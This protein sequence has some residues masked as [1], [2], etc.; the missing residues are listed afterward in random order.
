M[1]DSVTPTR[2]DLLRWGATAGAAAGLA[3]LL[4][5]CGSGSKATSGAV[6]AAEL[7]DYVPLKTVPAWLPPL[8][9]GVEAGYNSFPAAPP[10]S[11]KQP[12]LKG[13]AVDSFC[14]I[15]LPPPTPMGSN[16]AWQKVNQR[17]GGT[18]NVNYVSSADYQAKITTLMASNSLPDLLQVAPSTG[19]A[20]LY[21]FLQ[22]KC[23][24]L[25]PKLAGSAVRKYPNLA[26]LP[27][28]AWKSSVLNGSL[29]GVP[30]PRAIMGS[31]VYA[32]QERLD[33]LGVSQIKNSDEFLRVLKELTRPSQNQWAVCA[34]SGT[35]FRYQMAQYLFHVP[36]NWKVDSSGHFTSALETEQNKEAVS[37]WR[38]AVAA[39][40]VLPGSES[41]TT[42]QMKDAFK[43]GRAT[44]IMDGWAN[45]FADYWDSMQKIDP[46][47]KLRLL[48]L[49]GA[50]GGNQTFWYSTGIFSYTAIPQSSQQKVD[51]LLGVLN[52]LAAPFGS[53]EFQL[54]Y[55]GVEGL[56]FQRV[57]GNLV[58]TAQGTADLTVPW[59]YLGAGPEVQYDGHSP[60][61]TK[62]AYEGSK[63]LV[64]L[65]VA[66]PTVGLY[67]NTNSTRGPII[68]S[69]FTTGLTDIIAGRRP[70]SDY[71]SLVSAWKSSGG[72]IIRSE[73]QKAHAAGQKKK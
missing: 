38:Q 14:L 61:A 48:V 22:A 3:P 46:S 18:L 15:Y 6:T 30:V 9:N 58:P 56:E 71:D 41:F 43:S 20:N 35:A 36:N 28:F 31:P 49:P 1:T 19:I 59:K 55:Y 34:S 11:V 65:G 72:D 60:D 39:G 44:L 12:P 24:D 57:S 51:Q 8:A 2:R 54:L 40:V 21:P 29:Y 66:D 37:F 10:D 62:W 68:G 13:G 67:S 17:L 27:T 53:S 50:H 64:P 69:T 73:Y 25:T 63:A 52:F 26:N 33:Q 47:F 5:A 16:A 7:P 45:T 42:N 4:A 70:F 23:V 32:H